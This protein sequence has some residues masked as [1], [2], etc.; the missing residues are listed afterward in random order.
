MIEIMGHSVLRTLV[1]EITSQKWFSLLA[2][3]TR[4]ITNCEQIVVCLR[5]VSDDYE[6][7]EDFLNLVQLENTTSQ[8]IYMSLKDCIIRLGLSFE[9]CRG[10]GYDGAS[11]FQGCV[12]GV[13]KR[14]QSEYPALI[15]VHCL[16]HCINLC[17]QD[18]TR[19]CNSVKQALNFSMELIHL[20]KLPPKRQVLFE[21]IQKQQDGQTTGIRTLCPTR[22]T[23]RTGAMQAIVSNY[24]TLQET[25]EVVSHGTDDCSRRASGVCALMDKFST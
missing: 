6:V 14:F 7:F 3:E 16:A 24:E 25:M 8:M 22:W 23:V 21:N 10:Q 5:Y 1:K 9:N 15:P 19:S 13:A 20:I 18:L 2:D 12:N 17:L 11:N 4:D